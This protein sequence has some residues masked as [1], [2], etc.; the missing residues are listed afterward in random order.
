M[1]SSIPKDFF[2]YWAGQD[3]RFVN[4]M[5]VISLIK[6]SNPKSI[7]IYSSE[8]PINN[9][10]WDL[11]KKNK[12][13]KIVKL[14]LKQLI[15]ENKFKVEDFNE[16]FKKTRWNHLTD[17]FRYLIL[18]KHGGVYLDFDVLFVKHS[19]IAAK[20]VIALVFHENFKAC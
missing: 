4:Y 6:T 19:S 7:H 11:L 3:F 8:E 18:Y 5:S 2:F 12:D 1:Q 9:K 17:L 13:V 14:N 15:K 10:Y 20:T 16:F